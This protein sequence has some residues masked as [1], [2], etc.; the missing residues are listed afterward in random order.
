MFRCNVRSFSLVVAVVGLGFVGSPAQAQE[1]GWLFQ[2][3]G[4]S[5]Y[6][7]QPARAVYYAPARFAAPVATTPAIPVTASTPIEVRLPTSARLS[8]NGV[9]TTPTGMVRNFVAPSLA[10]GQQYSYTVRAEWND[11][12]RNV[13][14]MK[15]ISFV[16]GQPVNIDFTQPT[17][18]VNQ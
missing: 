13:E 15:N 1:Q 6:S 10:V 11:G 3:R 8:F 17:T 7:S 16:G 14:Q 9:A 4:G 2:G 5:S 18:L 12:T